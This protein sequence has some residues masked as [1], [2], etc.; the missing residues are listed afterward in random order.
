[1]KKLALVITQSEMGGA[2]K[3]ILL[4]ANSLKDQYDITVYSASGGMMIDEL[5]KIGVKFISVPNMVREINLS[6]DF[7][8]YKFLTAEFKSK[9]FDIVH[10][11][12]S[13]A[14]IL[15]RMAA[16]KANI[17]NVVYTAHGFVFNEPMSTIKRNIYI[18]LERYAAKKT[19]TIISVSPYDIDIAKAHNIKPQNKF[20]YIPNGIDFGEAQL[21]VAA[22][23]S[24]LAIESEDFIFGLVGN[25]YETKGHRY[26]ISA[27]NNLIKDGYNAKLLLVG[28][29]MLKEEMEQLAKDNNNIKFLGFRADGDKIVKIFDC[30]VMSSVKEGFPFVILEAIKNRVPVI[31]TDVGAISQILDHGNL[32]KIVP[33][34]DID[35]LKQ[36]MI[37]AISNV[38][39][40]RYTADKAY[41]SCKSNYSLENMIEKTKEIYEII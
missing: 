19:N 27:F 31:S 13:K 1:M 10:C 4:L 16:S 22:T 30:F 25:F 8:A 28:D 5:E 14:G 23:K 39:N 7:K 3:S 18:F 34:K 36:A 40:L 33:A 29:G 6:N 37:E 35:A 21:D 38:E 17:R 24:E 2:Q 20:C 12:S 41:E 9:K 32:G 15:A 26:L 11:H